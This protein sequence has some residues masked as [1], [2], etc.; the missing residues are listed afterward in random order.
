MTFV[1]R[2]VPE[3]FEHPSVWMQRNEL[4]GAKTSHSHTRVKYCLSTQGGGAS[5]VIASSLTPYLAPFKILFS[6]ATIQFQYRF[7]SKRMHEN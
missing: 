1:N 4:K 7:S 2:N 6:V 5:I 3:P